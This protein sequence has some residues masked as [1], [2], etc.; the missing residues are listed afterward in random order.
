MITEILTLSRLGHAREV[1][2]EKVIFFTLAALYVTRIGN[3][4]TIRVFT[5]IT[6]LTL[7][8]LYKSIYMLD[9]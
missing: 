2:N 8:W 4:L 6:R 7:K 1:F 3:T 5:I 9:L